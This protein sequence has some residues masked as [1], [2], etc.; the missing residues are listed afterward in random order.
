MCGWCCSARYHHILQGPCLC[1]N[2]DPTFLSGVQGSICTFPSSIFLIKNNLAS[3]LEGQQLP[4]SYPMNFQGWLWLEPESS[5]PNN[6]NIT[7]TSAY[8]GQLPNHVSLFWY[9]WILINFGPNVILPS[10]KRVNVRSSPI[11]YMPMLTP[12]NPASTSPSKWWHR[13]MDTLG[14][15]DVLSSHESIPSLII[16]IGPTLDN[17]LSYSLLVAFR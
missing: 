14:M 3:W 13:Q 6:S 10:S 5:L 4:Q 15:L 8:S 16:C 17:L 7:P 12:T 11:L 1:V 9:K 2:L